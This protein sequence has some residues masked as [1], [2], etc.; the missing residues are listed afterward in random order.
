VKSSH[1]SSTRG[2][3]KRNAVAGVSGTAWN[4]LSMAGG[5][6]AALPMATRKW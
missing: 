5:Q 6:D 1:G 4:F 2:Y 3:V